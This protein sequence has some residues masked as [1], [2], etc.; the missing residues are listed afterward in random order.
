MEVA[1]GAGLAVTADLLVPEQGFTKGDGRLL[2]FDVPG[3]VRGA[4]NGN[5]LERGQAIA[6]TAIS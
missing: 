5:S 4:R 3:K 6:T 2:V 1:T